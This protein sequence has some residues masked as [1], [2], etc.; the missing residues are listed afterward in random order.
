MLDPRTLAWRD[1]LV[2]TRDITVAGDRREFYRLVQRGEFVSLRRGVY[3]RRS[4]WDDLDEDARYLARV[5]AAV[6]FTRGSLVVSH[7]SAAAAWR[8]PWLGKYPFV[9]H[10]VG[11][12]GNGGRHTSA[13]RMHALSA[14][15]EFENIEGVTVTS[16]GRTVID[17]ARTSS[18][19]QA[20]VVADAA[21]RRT[22]SPIPGLP[23][24]TLTA[25][26]LRAEIAL[27]P[28]RNGTAKA[29]RVVDFADG[30]ADSPGE[31]ISR[32]NISLAGLAAPILQ[33][34]LRG[35]SGRLWEVDFWWPNFNLI[36]EFDGKAK[37]TDEKYLNGRTPQQALYDEKMRED[38]LRA[39]NHGFS[40]WP[41]ATA[42]SMPRLREHLIQAGVR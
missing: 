10:A 14:P 32:V 20:V 13:I 16:L 6:A 21:L 40:R 17:I 11:D 23:L 39:A 35:A 18:F 38:D 27:F 26:S 41:W 24:A 37:Y 3:M 36:G 7:L 4:R 19:V 25:D 28:L 15:D 8:L 30:R 12:F 34:P 31:S 9:I 22:K 33:A 42:I 29:R 1:H 5:Q 2:L